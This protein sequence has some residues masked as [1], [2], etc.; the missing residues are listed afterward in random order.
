MLPVITMQG[1]SI[2]RFSLVT[3]PI[4]GKLRIVNPGLEL[5]W[6]LFSKIIGMIVNLRVISK[7]TESAV[8]NQPQEHV[9][10]LSFSS[11]STCVP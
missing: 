10:K 11:A 1:S 8:A 3:F 2:F 4:F 6:S 7:L 9:F 5:D